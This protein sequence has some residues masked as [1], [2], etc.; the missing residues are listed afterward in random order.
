MCTLFAANAIIVRDMMVGS[1]IWV[2][3]PMLA[4]ITNCIDIP[5][6]HWT[7]FKR[8]TGTYCIMHMLLTPS[9]H[10]Y[11]QLTVGRPVHIQ[12]RLCQ[13]PDDVLGGQMCVHVEC[14]AE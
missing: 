6:D 5:S 13:L 9:T 8:Q 12:H 4:S 11:R 3:I 7:R 1:T 10:L 14:R 2:V